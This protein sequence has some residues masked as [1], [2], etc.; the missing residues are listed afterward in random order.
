MKTKR[1][2]IAI[3][4]CVLTVIFTG[5]SIAWIVVPWL[6]SSDTSSNSNPVASTTAQ[7]VNDITCDPRE[8]SY[9]HIHA[10]L[11]IFVNRNPIL[12]HS[13]I[14]IL[15]DRCIYWIHT[16]DDKGIIHI[17]SPERR[18]F[19]LGEFFDVWGQNFDN[20]QIFDNIVEPNKNRTIDVYL[21]G[22]K[23][24]PGTDYRQIPINSHDQ[25]AIVFGKAP[26]PI[27]STYEF[28]EGL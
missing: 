21:N 8:H 27:P 15:P 13:D 18:N 7:V 20:N 9:H 6:N 22:N 23:V 10:H 24:S 5:L 28:P 12:V 17:E 4:A 3:G 26:K 16:H 11:N 2:W 14:G 25:I 19:T 1:M